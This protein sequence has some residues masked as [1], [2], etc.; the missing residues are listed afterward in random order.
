MREVVK[1]QRGLPTSEHGIWWLIYDKQRR[2]TV[3]MPHKLVPDHLKRALPHFGKA[4][5]EAEWDQ[6]D[7]WNIL[8]R[9]GDIQDF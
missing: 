9:V 1:V 2:R 4:Y 7:G 5:F 6:G 3:E 8:D